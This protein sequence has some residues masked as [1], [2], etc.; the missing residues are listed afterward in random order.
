MKRTHAVEQSQ[1]KETPPVRSQ[2]SAGE[3]L[4]L[5]LFINFNN[6]AVEFS[7]LLK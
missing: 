2:Q 1:A 3:L 4:I 5:L 7:S 6:Q